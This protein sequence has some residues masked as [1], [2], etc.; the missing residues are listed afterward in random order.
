[1]TH[2]TKEVRPSAD[3]P[4]RDLFWTL[5]SLHGFCRKEDLEEG[6]RHMSWSLGALPDRWMYLSFI[7]HY[8]TADQIGDGKWAG[9]GIR[10]D[11]RT[12]TLP[13]GGPS[14]TQTFREKRVLLGMRTATASKMDGPDKAGLKGP[15]IVGFVLADGPHYMSSRMTRR[16]WETRG[17]KPVS[18]SSGIT[19]FQML[20]WSGVDEWNEGWNAS[21]GYIDRLHQAQ[22]GSLLPR[23]SNNTKFPPQN[24]DPMLQPGRGFRRQ[25][26]RE[27]PG[28]H[29]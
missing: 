11:R 21:L 22:V 28:P 7:F 20:L 29:V 24:V 6:N 2:P 8:F 27:A 16:D 1:M 23:L 10:C 9:S 13:L 3:S 18:G 26:P 4:D 5:N 12:I 17:I 14:G 25:R 15:A 19:A